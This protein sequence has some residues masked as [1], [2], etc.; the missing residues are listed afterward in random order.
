DQKLAE[1]IGQ[2]FVALLRDE[3]KPNEWREMLRRN[4]T[5]EY[6]KTSCCASHDFCDANLVMADAF[7]EHVGRAVHV[8]DDDPFAEHDTDLW[9]AAWE[10]ARPQL[11][12]PR[13]AEIMA[14][15]HDVG[16]VSTWEYPG[17][18]AI[19]TPTGVWSIGTA[20]G[21]WGGDFAEGPTG[22]CSASFELEGS[23]DATRDDAALIAKRII[24]AM[25]EQCSGGCW[26]L[27]A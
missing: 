23:S 11:S 21:P 2:T 6:D 8:A 17:F 14:C 27:G 24:L 25:V 7:E 3:L 19:S 16:I 1:T 5:P 18:I 22:E 13:P 10:S 9:N 4:A 15:L 26:G 12:G 20:N